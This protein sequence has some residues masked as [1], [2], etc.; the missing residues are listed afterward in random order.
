MPI[1]YL[2]TKKR[3]EI[4][5]VTSKDRELIIKKSLSKE[6]EEEKDKDLLAEF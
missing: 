3:C 5:G 4:E 1:I 2:T 6:L